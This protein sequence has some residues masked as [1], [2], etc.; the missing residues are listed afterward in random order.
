MFKKFLYYLSN[1][2]QLEHK[3]QEIP[4]SELEE[5]LETGDIILMHGEEMTSF[6]ISVSEMS[7][8]THAT[9]VV[10]SRDIGDDS[11]ELLLW[12][13][14][15][16]DKMQDV[17]LRKKKT[18]PQLVDLKERLKSNREMHT[19]NRFMLRHLYVDNREEMYPLL[20]KTIDKVHSTIFPPRLKMVKMVWD[21]RILG[22]E[23]N[24]DSFG[25][26]ELVAYTYMDMGLL[27]RK[28]PANQYEPRDFSRDGN[29]RL[30]KRA[31]FGPPIRIDVE[32]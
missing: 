3:P 9:M 14:N 24:F 18:G 10:R 7:Q 27:T 2:L 15:P 4:L 30:L 31:F 21:G 6:L 11:D 8:W 29:V 26:S 20:R 22:K 25:C 16:W 32:K 13:S 19:D 1:L 12:E 28:F 5:Y 17:E 23:A